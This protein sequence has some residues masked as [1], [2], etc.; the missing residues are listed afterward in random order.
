MNSLDTFFSLPPTTSP[1]S[2]IVDGQLQGESSS[3]SSISRGASTPSPVLF[4]SA[5]SVDFLSR[6][7][8]TASDTPSQLAMPTAMHPL[9]PSLSSFDGGSSW[10]KE[11]VPKEGVQSESEET[12]VRS[13]ERPT[14]PIRMAFRDL[15]RL[16]TTLALGSNGGKYVLVVKNVREGG[17]PPSPTLKSERTKGKQE[18]M[19]TVDPRK[20]ENL[21]LSSSKHKQVPKAVAAFSSLTVLDL[22]DNKIRG[23]LSSL[24]NLSSLRV[25]DLSSNRLE[26]LSPMIGKLSAL[27]VLRLGNNCLSSLPDEV[28][29]MVSLSELSVDHNSLRVLP[30]AIVKLT[31]LVQLNASFNKLSFDHASCAIPSTVV[32][33]NLSHNILA[34]SK[35][36]LPPP[37]V[38]CSR[39][40]DL[41]ISECGLLQFPVDDLQ[42]ETLVHLD[43]SE[44]EIGD[45]VDPFFD[46]KAIPSTSSSS[47]ISNTPFGQLPPLITLNLKGNY[48]RQ[49]PPWIEKATR[50]AS[51][52][53][54]GNW[55]HDIPS[56]V[57]CLTGLQRLQCSTNDITALTP[58]M[59]L[60]KQLRELDISNNPLRK[61]PREVKEMPSLRILTIRG[62]VDL[63]V[64]VGVA[65]CRLARPELNVEVSAPVP[66]LSALS[67]SSFIQVHQ[68]QEKKESCPSKTN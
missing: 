16:E 51:L 44:N 3:P 60:L 15:Q 10:V 23:D 9:S 43:V 61:F 45:Y 66:V 59:K 56:R 20:V 29:G 31:T 50:L 8:L 65:K 37:L 13:E 54:Q 40:T 35:S 39:L 22:S 19:I 4:S 48:L 68:I 55:L 21:D 25:L 64:A 27:R 6:Q 33:L 1:S 2:V 17:K 63:R 12:L 26:E 14:A 57:L 18:V 32:V 62:F 52:D 46:M 30:P 34:D 11:F 47:S 41:D 24:Q 5:K 49:V 7:L 42:P 53:L 38:G 67:S 58:E 28:G 36:R